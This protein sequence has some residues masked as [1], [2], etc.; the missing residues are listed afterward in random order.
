MLEANWLTLEVERLN[1]VLTRVYDFLWTN[2]EMI[3]E[4]IARF[5]FSS[6]EEPEIFLGCHI[7]LVKNWKD[8]IKG[9]IDVIFPKLL[10]CFLDLSIYGEIKR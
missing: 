5:S 10:L 1:E 6:G 3:L 7:L 9:S 8:Y 2:I 4:Q